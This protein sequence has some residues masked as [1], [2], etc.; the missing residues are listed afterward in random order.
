VVRVIGERVKALR[1]ERGLSQG[2]LAAKAGL[3]R[4]QICR[5]E[6]DERPGVQA[7]AV[8]QLAAA[9]HTTSDY[10]LGL[11]ADPTVPPPLEWR[12]DPAHLARLQRL[13]ERLVRLPLERQER[14]MDAVLT[15]LGVSEVVNGEGIEAPGLLRIDLA[16]QSDDR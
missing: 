2:Q 8:G 9:L 15:L 1:E 16:D 6:K 4:S 12:T 5:V 14:V 11:T 13:L 10:L 3:N 7:V